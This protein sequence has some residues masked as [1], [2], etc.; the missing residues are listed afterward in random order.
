MTCRTAIN[1]STMRKFK[2]FH[3]KREAQNLAKKVW[4][5]ECSWCTTEGKVRTCPECKQ[6][7][8]MSQ[9]DSLGE[10][11]YWGKLKLLEANKKI[12]DLELHKKF[13]F[14]M[15][16][17]DGSTRPVHG[18]SFYPDY[19]FYYTDRPGVI[20]VLDYKP[21]LDKRAWDATYIF[22]V[23]MMKKIYNITVQAVT[24]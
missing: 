5:C 12:I 17:M 18:F 7:H 6:E 20:Q 16:M 24:D 9:Y 22:K 23:S 15:M 8:L 4:V 10:W 13:R 21:S 11:R 1:K 14:P 19:T 2:P 3:S